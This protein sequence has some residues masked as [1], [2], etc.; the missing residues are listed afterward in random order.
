[1]S[2]NGSSTDYVN[3]AF[4]STFSITANTG[5][6]AGGNF[7]P[8][9]TMSEDGSVTLVNATQGTAA[10]RYFE[11]NFTSGARVTQGGFR[12]DAGDVGIGTT[13]PS[14]RLTVEGDSAGEYLFMLASSSGS[15]LY[16]I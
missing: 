9:F 10:D 6:D 13:T 8:A 15:S 16:S 2:A 4:P 7:Y 14:A 3:F 1:F 12:V 11:M 5:M